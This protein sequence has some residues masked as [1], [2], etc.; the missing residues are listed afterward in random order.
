MSRSN[1]KFDNMNRPQTGYMHTNNF[2]RPFSTKDGGDTLLAKRKELQS[3]A[4]ILKIES[5]KNM[6]KPPKADELI[7][8]DDKGLDTI[9]KQKPSRDVTPKKDDA[10]HVTEYSAAE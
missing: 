2:K 1:I 4:N 5:A 9:E 6:E 10:T 8:K 3:K 7:K